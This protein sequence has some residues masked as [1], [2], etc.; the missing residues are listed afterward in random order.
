MEYNQRR[1]TNS[2]FYDWYIGHISNL[3]RSSYDATVKFARM[4]ESAFQ[5]ETGD[6]TATFIG[7]HW[8]R[9]HK[10]ILAGQALWLDLQR[11]DLAYWSRIEP[12][13]EIV[14]EI[15]LLELQPS[16]VAS[17]QSRGEVVFISKRRYLR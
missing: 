6:L 3:Y 11:M 4:A 7:S 17:L 9:R 1:F 16:A 12:E 2:Q 10:G 8:D 13:T 5:I 15:S 14:K